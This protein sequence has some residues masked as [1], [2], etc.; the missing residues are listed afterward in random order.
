MLG[1][2]GQ[3]ILR[4]G[5]DPALQPTFH[6]AFYIK[7]AW[8]LTMHFDWSFFAYFLCKESRCKESRL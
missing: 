6:F 8:S 3:E 7:N 5:Q 2:G 1:C 4:R